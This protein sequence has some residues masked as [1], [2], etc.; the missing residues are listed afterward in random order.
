MSD[1]QAH[2]LRASGQAADENFSDAPAQAVVA[3]CPKASDWV[4]IQLLG[5]DDK[6]VAGAA[7]RL[8]LPDGRVVEGTLDGNG[9]ATVRGIAS[10]QCIVSFPELDQDAWETRP[11]SRG[12]L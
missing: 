10:G 4:E 5:E 3:P 8:E 7:Y 2:Q 12:P 6:G 9:L 11:E 1:D